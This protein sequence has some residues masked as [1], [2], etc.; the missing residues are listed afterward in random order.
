MAAFINAAVVMGLLP[1]KGL[2]LPFLSYGRTSLIMCCLVLGILL[3]VARQGGERDDR[4][5]TVR[6]RAPHASRRPSS[7]RAI[8]GSSRGIL[9]RGRRRAWR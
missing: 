6:R 9:G 7:S 2:T 8:L 3:G 4:E 1:T 5:T